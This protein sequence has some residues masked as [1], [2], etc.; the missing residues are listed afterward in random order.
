MAPFFVAI[1][2]LGFSSLAM[3]TASIFN[4]VFEWNELDF[5]WPSEESR[6]Q[7]VK[8]GTFRLGTI[9]PRFMA[10]YGSRIFLSL[11]KF[12]GIPVSLVSLPTSSASSAPP[13]LTPFPSWDMH[14][15]G[16]GNCNKFHMAQGLQV[17][18]IGRLWVLDEC[19]INCTAKLWIFDLSNN[20]TEL[21]H[22]LPF[23]A[24][25]MHDFVLDETPNETLAYITFWGDDYIL[26]FSLERKDSRIV[27]TPGIDVFSVALSP[28]DQEP[29]QQLY[30]G[31]DN[32]N[33]LYAIYVSALRNGTRTAEPK[34]IGTWD[35]VQSYRMLIDNHGIMYAAFLDNNSIYSWNTSQ[36]FRDHRFHQVTGLE[37]ALPFTFALDQNGTLWM[38]VFDNKREPR[39]RLLKAAVGTKSIEDSPGSSCSCNK[40]QTA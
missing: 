1:F 16:S 28:K 25:R 10:V 2:L 39:C 4:Q 15:N 30:L 6:T 23:R 34:L 31:K 3:A 5:E 12:P 20:K 9:E 40:R 7:A 18:S 24:N 29:R 37:H 36:P 22:R 21:L 11:E 38:T 33:K 32:S 35:A 19:S 8:D 27:D 26:V 13:K 17:D 14:L